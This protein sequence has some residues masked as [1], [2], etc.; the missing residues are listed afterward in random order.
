MIHCYGFLNS[1]NTI[2]NTI[3]NNEMEDDTSWLSDDDMSN[4]CQF[5][6]LVFFKLF[7]YNYR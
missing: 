4:N 5:K 1:I 7:K 2:A 3:D 6:I